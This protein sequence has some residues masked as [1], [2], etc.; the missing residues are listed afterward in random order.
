M[1]HQEIKKIITECRNETKIEFPNQ[2]G[3][4]TP[5]FK[6]IN[7]IELG[8]SKVISSPLA[9][10]LE[11]FYSIFKD[12]RNEL[13]KLNQF[14]FPRKESFFGNKRESIIRG[15]VTFAMKNGIAKPIH[16]M[17]V[18][19]WAKTWWLQWRRLGT[20]LTDDEGYYQIYY[21]RKAAKNIGILNLRLEVYHTSH[22]YFKDGKVKP[23]FS[24]FQKKWVRK[25]EL[26]TDSFM[27][28]NFRL[29]YWEYREDFPT[30]RVLIKDR[31]KDAPQY[32]SQARQ[33]AL[34]LQFI[35][36]ELTKAKHLE[37]LKLG[38]KKINLT[39]IQDDYP[40][41]LSRSIEEK[42]PGYTR[43]DEYFGN[44][45]M[46]GMNRA[47][48]FPDPENARNYQVKY[49]GSCQY[50]VN[51]IFAFPDATIQFKLDEEGLPLPVEITLT[52]PL[53]AFEK[54]QWKKNVFTPEDGKNWEYAKRIARVSG[55]L[56]TEVDDHFTGTH[57]NTEQYAIAAYR[58]LRLNPI[59][60]LLLPHLKEVVLI[61]HTADKLLLKDFLPVA[62]ALTEKGLTQ[63]TKDILGVQDW[64]GFHPMDPVSPAH[65][66]ASSD[67]LFWEITKQYVETYIDS[68]L[69]EIKKY[70]LEIHCFSQDLLEHSVPVFLSDVDLNRLNPEQQKQAGDRLEYYQFK[71]GFNPKLNRERVNGELKA[72]SPI[73]KNRGNEEITEKDIQ[74]LKESCIYIIFVATYLH[75]WIN[76]HQYDE[77]GELLFNG[78][79]LRFGNGENGILAP[80]SDLRIAPDPKR[81]T[82]MLWFVNLLSRTEF[83]FITR[84]E[85]GDINPEFS[86]L[87]INK[88]EEFLLLG[89]EVD[90]IESRT[91]I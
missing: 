7:P 13:T 37:M 72:I 48:F 52:G 90:N 65:D 53:S 47:S 39:Y 91:N 73:T 40:M 67:Q 63:R 66:V 79:G 29:D 27:L 17:S 36:N 16:H 59:A 42:I 14:L 83:G 57:L 32:Y 25:D 86:K 43:S 64:K 30:P 8:Q 20:G 51:E 44:R 4:F 88:K 46:N 76:E 49:F 81:A 2:R 5:R 23:N 87:L 38:S 71:Y 26:S 33:D 74:N 9:L 61:N 62:S 85:E 22:I 34:A 50:E 31:E 45:Q 80:E 68:H 10:L 12:L 60:N 15:R 35:P 69:E 56:C 19:F 75:T 70:W 28:G 77:L 3:F 1:T 24:L 11:F 78:L 82:D 58:N 6:S 55:S 54:D 84:N 18:E 21:D 41:N 89:V